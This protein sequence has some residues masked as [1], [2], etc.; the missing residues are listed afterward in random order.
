M[1]IPIDVAGLTYGARTPRMNPDIVPCNG[2]SSGAVRLFRRM[3][4]NVIVAGVPNTGYAGIIVQAKSSAV[5]IEMRA[6]FCVVIFTRSRLL[7]KTFHSIVTFY[8]TSIKDFPKNTVFQ[9]V[10]IFE[11]Y[12][13]IILASILCCF[14]A[15]KMVTL[16]GSIVS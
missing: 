15:V 16:C 7:C 9:F 10:V 1:R 14:L 12:V 2:P 5:Q 13:L 6:T 11:P 8:I 4:E 3:L